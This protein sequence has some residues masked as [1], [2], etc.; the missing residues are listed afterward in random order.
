[1]IVETNLI[2]LNKITLKNYNTYNEKIKYEIYKIS[3]IPKNRIKPKGTVIS[4]ETRK[5]Q[6]KE[7]QHEYYLKVTKPKRKA[8]KE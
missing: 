8:K 1:M 3:T 6:L 4:A 5:Q 7:Y 2:D